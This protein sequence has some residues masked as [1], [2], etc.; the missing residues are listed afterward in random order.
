MKKK[1]K[2]GIILVALVSVVVSEF[3]FVPKDFAKAKI[4][5][6]IVSDVQEY[7]RKESVQYKESLKAH[8]DL[9][10]ENNKI[11]ER[12]EEYFNFVYEGLCTGEAVDVSKEFVDKQSG[13]VETVLNEKK[14]EISNIADDLLDKCY[15]DFNYLTIEQN[16]ENVIVHMVLKASFHYQDAPH[17]L[18]SSKTNLYK[19]SLEKIDDN[20]KIADISSDSDLQYMALTEEFGQED[21]DNNLI[22]EK[23]IKKYAQEQ[24]ETVEKYLEETEE[25]AQK[26]NMSQSVVSLN[27]NLVSLFCP[28]GKSYSAFSNRLL[29][30]ESDGSEGIIMTAN[31]S[32]SYN[33]TN[34]VKYARLYAAETNSSNWVFARASLDCTNFVSQC[35]WA[36]Y[37]G[38][39]VDTSDFTKVSSN[40]TRVNNKKRM[41][42][43]WYGAKYGNG[44]ISNNFCGVT[45]FY[46]YVTDNSKSTGPQGTGYGKAKC[47]NFDL[48]KVRAGDVV[49]FYSSSYGNWRHSTYVSSV[50]RVGADE[51]KIFVCAHQSDH[52]DISITEY[53][54]TFSKARGIHFS[55]AKFSS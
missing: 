50:T 34:G 23:E 33:A 28:R 25:N 43:S 8:N 4:E 15:L 45:Y 1:V 22:T 35:V 12:I 14:V 11:C 40:R 53:L 20:W 26:M 54:T 30:N 55:S 19:I 41:T 31:S 49:Q 13:I 2:L 44:D 21:M 5:D 38:W 39:L 48:S 3:Q 27:N 17:D 24:V 36:A 42:G 16:K 7:R 10:S 51:Y 46:N 9:A 18:I 32:Y 37:G 52:K 47:E 6:N 29:Y